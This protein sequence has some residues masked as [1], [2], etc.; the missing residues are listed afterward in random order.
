MTLDRRKFLFSTGSSTLGA[1]FSTKFLPSTHIDLGRLKVADWAYIRELFPIVHWKK[2]HFNSGS[3]GVMPTYLIDACC[4]LMSELHQAAPYEVWTRWQDK[5]QNNLDALAHLCGTSSKQIRFVRNTTEGLNS[6]IS[7]VNL[8]I[9]DEILIAD[10]D[11]PYAVNAMQNRAKRD[12]LLLNKI[13]VDLSKSDDEIIDQYRKAIHSKTKLVLLTHMTHREGQLLP[14]KEITKIAQDMGSLVVVDGAHIVGQKSLNLD[15]I[16]ADFYVSSLHKWLNAAH[17]T[18]MIYARKSALKHLHAFSSSNAADEYTIQ[19]FEHLGTRGFYTEIAL[20]G[21]LEFHYSIGPEIKEERLHALTSYWVEKADKI[22]GVRIHTRP[23]ND[24]YG[25]VA[26][27]AI[28]KMGAGELL[29]HLDEDHHIH[30]KT[31][32]ASW[33]SGIRISTNVFTSF[34]ELDQLIEAIDILSKIAATK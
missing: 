14:I 22:E 12:Q 2:V 31:V 10:H 7:L 5:R 34:D 4:N 33:G 9:G 23:H 13:I 8:N 17:G 15:D 21:S 27:F 25:A 28:D 6:I 16:K 11:Y 20:S 3:A 26:T 32:G 30:A 19:Q 29:K 18:G 24:L 1:I